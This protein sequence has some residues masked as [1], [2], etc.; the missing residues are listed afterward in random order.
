MSAETPYVEPQALQRL[1][2]LGGFEL[3]DRMM[4]LFEEVGS[5][6][7]AAA[8]D[9]VAAGDLETAGR[10]AHSVKS[11]AGNLG[12]LRLHRLAQELER[13]AAAGEKDAAAAGVAELEGIYRESLRSLRALRASMEGAPEPEA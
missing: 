2:R 9:A 6:R 4:A 8:R 11:S 12:L 1:V 13:R 3:L 5:G 10:A 7:T